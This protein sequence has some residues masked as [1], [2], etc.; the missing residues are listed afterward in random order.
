MNIIKFNNSILKY[1]G[2]WLETDGT[3]TPSIWQRA[4]AGTPISNKDT[5]L[6][7]ETS[8]NHVSLVGNY[9]QTVTWDADYGETLPSSLTNGSVRECTHGASIKITFNNM[10]FPVWNKQ[11]MFRLLFNVIAVSSTTSYYDMRWDNGRVAFDDNTLTTRVNL[12]TDMVTKPN[13]YLENKLTRFSG[14]DSFNLPNHY[15]KDDIAI[16]ANE[17]GANINELRWYINE[18]DSHIE[19]RNPS[20]SEPIIIPTSTVANDLNQDGYIKP[21]TLELKSMNYY[22][23]DSDTSNYWNTS[24]KF[25]YIDVFIPINDQPIG[26]LFNGDWI[27]NCSST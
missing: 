19:I 8:N 5:G 24:I 14:L 3:P 13:G 12:N 2:K 17:I 1:D 7:L 22:G 18:N 23:Y 21:V 11:I 9:N 26:E 4:Y 16:R 20:I 6:F 25:G 10:I 15:Y 27:V